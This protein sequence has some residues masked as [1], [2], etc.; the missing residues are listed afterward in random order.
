M[1]NK[2]ERRLWVTYARSDDAEGDFS[3]LVQELKGV[4]VTAT[5]DRV[6]LVPGRSIWDRIA[7]RITKD[8]IDGWAYL[9]TPRSLESDRCREELDY[10]LNRALDTKG[11]T[12]PLI[13]LLHDVQ[14]DDLP[15]PL[16]V[17]LCVNLADPEW[18]DQ[19]R[20]GLDGKAPSAPADKKLKFIFRKY[21]NFRGDKGLK[22]VEIRPRYG[23]VTPWCLLVPIGT[24]IERCGHGAAGG[25]EISTIHSDFEEGVGPEIQ[26]VKTQMRRASDRLS[27]SVAAYVTFRGPWPTFVALQVE[28]PEHPGFS[29]VEVYTPQKT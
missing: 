16:K 28:A 26:G 24:A 22:A 10:A 2:P 9:L 7:E 23:E 29:Y 8:P 21:E 19:V 14:I 11:R 20:A 6:A 15:P 13:G 25:G 1:V 4:N 3:Y 17:R 27:A 18:K 5:Y 12:F